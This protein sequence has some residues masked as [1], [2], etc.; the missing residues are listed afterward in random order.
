ML[1]PFG[2]NYP[3]LIWLLYSELS[4]ACLGFDDSLISTKYMAEIGK[5]W[6]AQVS[7]GGT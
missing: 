1:L 2:Q 6:Q 5:T 3:Y 7:G 4:L